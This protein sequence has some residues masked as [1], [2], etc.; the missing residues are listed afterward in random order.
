[1]RRFLTELQEV[2][3]SDRTRDGVSLH[4]RGSASPRGNRHLH[5]LRFSTAGNLAATR[6]TTDFLLLLPPVMF[7]SCTTKEMQM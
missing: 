5:R 4:H 1:M 6:V 2:T 7:A 3:A